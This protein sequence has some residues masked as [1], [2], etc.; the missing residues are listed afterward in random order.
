MAF[1]GESLVNVI[2][3][4][5]SWS[6]T[7]SGTMPWRLLS[8]ARARGIAGRSCTARAVP[9]ERRLDCLRAELARGR[10]VIV[11]LHSGE[12]QHYVVVEGF[13][14]DEIHI[15]DPAW[16]A[17]VE[18]RS[19]TVDGNGPKPGNRTIA[20]GEFLRM[21]ARGGIAGLYGWWYAPMSRAGD[22]S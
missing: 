5:F 19:E 16:T 13:A 20:G 9:E 11:L 4:D 10:A 21:W 2:G 18:R 3:N 6:E 15:Y 7:L 14:A 8:E 1:S 22:G 17:S 12:G